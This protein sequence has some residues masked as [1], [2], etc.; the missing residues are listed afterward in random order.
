MNFLTF[1]QQKYIHTYMKHMKST[2]GKLVSYNYI[3][4][5]SIDSIIYVFVLNFFFISFLNLCVHFE[6]ETIKNIRNGKA[7]RNII[8]CSKTYTNLGIILLYCWQY[9]T[10]DLFIVHN[11]TKFCNYLYISYI[12]LFIYYV[13]TIINHHYKIDH[14]LNEIMYMD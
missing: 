10:N 7:K 1:L 14:G 9:F 6:K 5:N 4:I 2:S 12:N 11:N 3:T 8:E 13:V